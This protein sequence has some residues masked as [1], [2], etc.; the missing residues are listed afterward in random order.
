VGIFQ[1]E[2]MRNA[3]VAVVLINIACGI[4]GTYVV[5]KKIVKKVN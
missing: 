3:L 5:I 2:F 1:Y 4:V